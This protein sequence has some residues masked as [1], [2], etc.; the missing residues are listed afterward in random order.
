MSGIDRYARI[1]G[2]FT[3]QASE[4]TVADMS[5]EL[6]TSSST[7]Y[8]LVRELVSIG[9]LEST[10]ESR[11]RLGPYFIEFYRRIK[12]NDPLIRSGEI[13]LSPLCKQIEIPGT[14]VLARLYNDS[15][16]CVADDRSPHA[17]FETSYELGRP[18]PILKGATSK[19]VLSTMPPRVARSFLQKKVGASS[20]EIAAMEAELS[21]IRKRGI[22]ETMG[23]VDKRL[24]GI[25]APVRNA[26]LGINASLSFIVET[27]QL[28]DDLRIPIYTAL[29][30][31]AKMIENFMSETSPLD[32]N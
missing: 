18:M 30:T 15:V 16:M 11:Y 28:T 5:E 7:L 1:L 31:T 24:T 4:W 22:C 23:E 6:E 12:L 2:L 10:V 25:A 19:V 21:A 29:T 26:Q 9:M 17:Q 14:A 32:A 13:F 20:E 8:R 3:R 27:H